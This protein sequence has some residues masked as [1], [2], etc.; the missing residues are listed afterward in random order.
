MSTMTKEPEKGSRRKR[1]WEAK[2]EMRNVG[3]SERGA[4]LA[5][6]AISAIGA[7][8]VGS[9]WLRAVLGIVGAAGLVTG[10]TGYCPAN[11]GLGRDSYHRR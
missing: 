4:R 5:V 9:P 8:M 6:G 2:H 3:G 7:F 1:V 11:K 10:G